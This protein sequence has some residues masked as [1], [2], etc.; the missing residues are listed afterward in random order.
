MHVAQKNP[1]YPRF[2]LRIIR[3]R[4]FSYFQRSSLTAPTLFKKQ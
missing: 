1:K 2:F 3:S 4:D